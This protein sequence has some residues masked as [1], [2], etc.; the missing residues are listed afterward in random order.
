VA[1]YKYLDTGGL[2]LLA[3][4]RIRMSKFSYT[5]D[6]FEVLPRLTDYPTDAEYWEQDFEK[7]IT[8]SPGDPFARLKNVDPEAFRRAKADYASGAI[9]RRVDAERELPQR[10][11]EGISAKVC[12]ICVTTAPSDIVM[13]SHYANSHRGFVVEFDEAHPVFQQVEHPSGKLKRIYP[14]Q[15]TLTRPVI[16][17][18]TVPFPFELLAIKA[19]Q[20]RYESEV[21]IL[22]W[23]DACQRLDGHHYYPLP[24]E[25][26]T[27]VTC[28]MRMAEADKERLRGILRSAPF[29]G[30]VPLLQAYESTEAFEIHARRE[31]V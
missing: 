4:C 11:R 6:P 15:Y 24:P 20:W 22:F 27:S 5:N 23:T 21:R 8:R 12:F 16:R 10:L 14:I 17:F 30:R 13:W 18:G 28:G 25:C 7:Q 31:S 26:I 1:F 3:N 19:E 29:G 2:D 9:N